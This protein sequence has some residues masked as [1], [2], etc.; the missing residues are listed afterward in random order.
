VLIDGFWEVYGTILLMVIGFWCLTMCLGEMASALPFNGG[1]YGF[2]R[3]TMG[4][5]AGFIVGATETLQNVLCVSV[6]VHPLGEMLTELT[7]SPRH[8]EP[9]YWVIFYALALMICLSGDRVLWSFI[10]VFGALFL[11]LTA[12]Y[13]FGSI[14]VADFEKYVVHSSTDPVFRT[15]QLVQV[16]PSAAWFFIGMESLP[17]VGMSAVD[18]SVTSP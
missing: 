16:L 11:V 12:V 5:F 8:Y 17:L 2:I 10:R 15:V 3:L 6:S 7:G 4:S 1:M 13:I 18:V 14:G 9:I